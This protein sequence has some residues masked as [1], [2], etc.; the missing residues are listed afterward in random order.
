[1]H[2]AVLTVFWIKRKKFKKN[3]QNEKHLHCV[4][5]CDLI[6]RK[7]NKLA[8]LKIF[9]KSGLTKDL[10]CLKFH[11]L[12]GKCLCYGHIHGIVC[13]NEPI[14]C[15]HIRLHMANNVAKESFP[16]YFTKKPFSIFSVPEREFFV[17]HVQE[18]VSKRY[19]T[20]FLKY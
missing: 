13:L 14:L 9:L 8:I 20:I 6:S 5:L 7:N 18:Y 15:T 2:A 19:H 10:S 17:K 16:L 1:M 3:Q 11:E 4:M 12:Q